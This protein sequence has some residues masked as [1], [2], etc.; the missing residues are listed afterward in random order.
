V[1][2]LSPAER[3]LLAEALGDSPESTIS[4]HF[5][6][7]G[8]GHGYVVGRPDSFAA[9]IVQEIADPRE[10]VGFGSDAGAMWSILRDLPG[11][12]CVCVPSE[13]APAL[14]RLV[15]AE[16]GRPVRYY[17]DVYHRLERPAA[18]FAHEAVRRLGPEDAA[19]LDA[20]PAELRP[21]SWGSSE[22]LLEEGIAAAGIV[23]GAVVAIAFTS[24]RTAA[25]AD[26]GVTT[27]EPWRGRG[28]ATAAASLVA[29][30]IQ[31]AGQTP[32]WS[33][34]EGNLASLRVAEKVGFVELGRRT[35]VIPAP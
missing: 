21:R 32:V 17:G 30:A 5:L 18:T 4:V 16:R 10:P 9:A 13:V 22:R 6:A 24:A 25:H 20:A 1:Q 8:L 31:A 3:A 33:T 19:L 15:E 23:A 34:G 14:G 27:L 26:I 7:R 12:E 28:L 11:W 35:Y 2:P 29:A